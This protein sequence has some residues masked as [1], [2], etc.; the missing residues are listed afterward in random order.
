MVP[1]VISP[2]VMEPDAYLDERKRFGAPHVLILEQ[3]TEKTNPR[4]G[5]GSLP[6]GSFST[7]G[8]WM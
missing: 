6:V 1:H 7:S 2:L 4:V 8:W 3:T 5:W